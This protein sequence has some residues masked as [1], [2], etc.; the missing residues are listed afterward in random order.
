MKVNRLEAHDRLLHFKEDQSLNIFQGAEDCLKRNPLSLAL[1]AESHYVYLFAHP[2]TA[3]DGITKVIYWQPRLTK[4]EAQENSYLFRAKSHTDELETMWFLPPKEMWKQ[5][6]T[7]KMLN[8]DHISISIEN[9]KR[10]KKILERPH[11]DDLPEERIR[12]IYRKM[13]FKPKT[14]ADSLDLPLLPS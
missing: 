11:E 5:F 6:E 14:W 10:H 7:G 2:R 1:Q 9:Y 3:E 4:P 12:D 13:A 8:A